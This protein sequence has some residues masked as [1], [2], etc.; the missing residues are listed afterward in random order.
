MSHSAQRESLSKQCAVQHVR[1][2]EKRRVQV[3]F[4]PEDT[5]SARPVSIARWICMQVYVYIGAR[6]H[7]RSADSART[8]FVDEGCCAQSRFW[9]SPRKMQFFWTRDTGSAA[10]ALGFHQDDAD[11]R[12]S[13]SSTATTTT[14]TTIHFAFWDSPTLTT[15]KPE[16]SKRVELPSTRRPV[17]PPLRSCS[18][19]TALAPLMT[20]AVAGARRPLAAIAALPS[21]TTSS[22]RQRLARR[23]RRGRSSSSSRRP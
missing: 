20:V 15:G 19:P 11:D 13:S 5:A 16:D 10:S 8:L 4:A 21:T 23:S 18:P 14:P 7:L 9:A 2:K 3:S 12:S 22:S 1:R 17:S 6:I